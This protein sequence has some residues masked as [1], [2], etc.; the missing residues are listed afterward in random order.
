MI[1]FILSKIIYSI[2]NYFSTISRGYQVDPVGVTT[3]DPIIM[4][5][6]KNIQTI[7]SFLIPNSYCLISRATSQKL[8]FLNEMDLRNEIFVANKSPLYSQIF[9]G[10]FSLVIIGRPYFNCKVWRARY[11]VVLVPDQRLYTIGMSLK[12]FNKHI[13]LYIN[14]FN[15]TIF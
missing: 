3:S 9:W 11:K 15:E 10:K 1:P 5:S 2:S 6:G 12:L 4:V 14:K 7:T 8:S 13:L